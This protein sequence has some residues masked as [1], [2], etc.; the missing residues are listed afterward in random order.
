MSALLRPASDQPAPELQPGAPARRMDAGM[1][2]VWV[3]L[4][5][6]AGLLGLAAS[7]ASRSEIGENSHFHVFWAGIFAF[8]VPAAWKLLSRHTRD[9][10]RYLIVVALGLYS[11]LPKFLAYPGRPAFFDEYAHWT[12]VERMF[13]DGLLFM[14]NNQVVVIGDYPAMHTTATSLR[15]L[16]GL[17]TY[18]VSVVM[19][20]ALHVVALIG[21]M[22]IGTRIGGSR[23]VGGIAALFYAIGPGFWYFNSQFAYESFSIILFIW[24]VTSLVHMQMSRTTSWNRTAWLI[25]GILISFTLTGSHHLSSYSNLIVLGAFVAASF[26]LVV[27]R[28]ESPANFL[29][30]LAFFV[31]VA[32]LTGWWFV[33][34]A[35]NTRAY[36]QPYIEGG[37]SETAGFLSDTE[38]GGGEDAA[39]QRELFSGSTIPLYEKVLSFATP[40]LVAA[41][42]AFAWLVQWRRGMKRSSALAMAFVAGVY[43]VVYPMMLSETG[44]EGARRSWSFTNVGVAV[45]IALGVQ[46]FPLARRW[47]WRTLGT[48]GVMACMAII[49]IGNIAAGTNELYRFPGP[50]VFGSDTRSTT[51]ELFETAAWFR[52]TQGPDQGLI[53]DRTNQIVFASRALA[54]LGVPSE[55][56][57]VWDFIV[58][59]EPVDPGLLDQVA[60]EDL[61]FVV[62]DKRQ[63]EFIPR[64][65]F[66]LDQ[67]EP[68]AGERT[69][70]VGIGSLTKWDEMPYALRIYESDHLIVYRLDP[71][72]FDTPYRV[73]NG[74]ADVTASAEA[75]T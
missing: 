29:E 31:I 42:A 64:T 27:L 49:M 21:V 62:I 75:A 23:H 55:S 17:S 16:T 14:R 22:A 8:L 18:H 34:E 28:K 41:M 40:V 3:G 63:I 11:Y 46:I 32:L 43:F 60:D 59:E 45:L 39:A 71:T 26:V 65:K 68:L 67:K 36:L 58:K 50:Y 1:V 6:G 66:Y 24:S 33:N 52:E 37:I 13:H 56:Y 74:L 2:V 53:S 15:H 72:S 4:V 35:P 20:L 57:P 51:N 30:G 47:T 19:L 69:E 25:S 12:Q 70:P 10:D 44:A 38:T 5:I 73:G 54:I 7:D 9:L 48:V 61:R